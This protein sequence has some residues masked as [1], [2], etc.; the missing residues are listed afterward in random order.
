MRPISISGESWPTALAML[1]STGSSRSGSLFVTASRMPRS[2]R[3]SAALFAPMPDSPPAFVSSAAM[4]AASLSA[5]TAMPSSSRT[6]SSS[7]SNDVPC[8]QLAM[9]WSQTAASP[10]ARS[11]STS[12]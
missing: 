2:I 7:S 8:R 3:N 10:P 6:A 9:T 11:R 4:S 5:S 12:A 1:R